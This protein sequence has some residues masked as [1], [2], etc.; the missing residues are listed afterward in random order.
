MVANKNWHNMDVTEVMASLKSSSLGL[1]QEEAKRRL[2]EFGPNELIAKKRVS[3]WIIFLR[4]FQNFFIII[5][6]VAVVISAI[7]GEIVDSM[8]IAVIVLFACGLGFIQEY[9]AERAMEALK[10]MAAPMAPVIRDGE[11]IEIASRDLVPGD[12]IS[13]RTGDRIPADARLIEAINLKID[14]VPLTGE[15]IPVNKVTR[16]ITEEVVVGDRNNMVYMGTA[17][18]Y[19]RGKAIVTATGM[20]TEFGKIAGMLQDVEERPTPL[21]ESLDHLGKWIAIGAITLCALLAILG[22]MRGHKILE[23]FIWGVSLAI[24]AVPEALPAVVTMGL[25]IGVQR[26]VRRHALIKKLPAVEALGC[27]TVI[28]S[29]KTGTLTQDQMTVSKLY[30]NGRI[31]DVTGVGYEPSGQ[32]YSDGKAIH[33][34]D[35]PHLKRLLHICCLCND[36]G[37]KSVNGVWE[38]KGDPTEGA[39][40][41]VAAKAGIWQDEI[42]CQFPRVREVPFSSERKRMTTIHKVSRGRF[43]YS[44]GACEVIL[45]SCTHIYRDGRERRLDSRDIEVILNIFQ[46]MANNAL[47]VLAVAYRHLPTDIELPETAEQEMVFVGLVG[48]MDPPREEVKEGIRL[49]QRAGIRSIMITGDHKLTAMAIAKKIGLLKRGIAL[50]GSELDKLGDD[51]LD[52]MVENID[53]YAR[54]SPAH[55]LRIVNA[56][57]KDGHVVAMTGDGINDAPALKKADIG[58]A[59]GV[60]GTDVTKEAADMVLT[61]DNFTSIV[62]AVEEGRG[63]FVNIKK[64]LV[65]LL[66]CNLGEILLMAA[67]IL[68]GPLMQLPAGI[69]PLVAVQILYVNLAPDGLPAIALSVEPPDIDIMDRPPRPRQNGIFTPSVLK[70][71]FGLVYGRP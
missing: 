51:E 24:A 26:M 14:E 28:C 6:L 62:A 54:V 31:F 17:A 53:V 70:F 5:L 23:M 45:N 2:V 9:R 22:I 20:A 60:T 12:V 34:S 64:Y 61:D 10:R 56:L 27:T 21:Q 4:Q 3:P 42:S 43:A 67:A 41:V 50:S 47:R 39:L 57:T 44:K 15:S 32:F 36:A 35:D 25:A 29:D 33:P 38:I 46:N 13:L 7:L 18:V 40:L 69:L 65:Y 8:V 49:C 68:V 66:S 11:E 63:I 37:L 30:A 55:K 1:S 48:M 58:I 59:M 19:G 71:L 16:H 52:E